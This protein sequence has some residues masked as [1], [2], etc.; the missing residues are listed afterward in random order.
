MTLLL[1]ALWITAAL[2]IASPALAQDTTTP[3]TDPAPPAEEEAAP[4]A[5]EPEPD[6]V[7]EVFGDWE[8]RCTP[9]NSN[10]FMYQV[11]LNQ[12]GNPV[13]EVSI[14]AIEGQQAAAGATIVTPLGTLLTEGLVIQVDGGEARRY[15]YQFCNRS[16]CFSRFGIDADYLLSLKRGATA[17]MRVFSVSNPSQPVTLQLSLTGFTAAFDGLPPT[18]LNQ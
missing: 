15:E 1:R 7:T 10:C 14:V 8:R 5:P 4:A 16:G 12:E 13:S 2:A 9:D 3:P 18:T 11:A 6:F 17:L